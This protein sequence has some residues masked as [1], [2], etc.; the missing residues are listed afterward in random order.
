MNLLGCINLKQEQAGV[1]T[2]RQVAQNWKMYK[3][4]CKKQNKTAVSHEER[5]IK[6]I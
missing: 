4:L 2:W 6:S 3:C 1:H 5:N